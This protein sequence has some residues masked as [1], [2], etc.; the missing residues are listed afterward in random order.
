MEH[1]VIG[2]H[3]LE[4]R[5]LIQMYVMEEDVWRIITATVS[6]DT[7]VLNVNFIIAMV[8]VTITHRLAAAW[9]FVSHLSYVIA[10]R[11]TTDHIANYFI[12]LE[13]LIRTI[14][15]VDRTVNVSVLI[16]AHVVPDIMATNVT[17]FHV[18]VLVVV[19]VMCAVEM[20]H[21]LLVTSVTV[22]LVMK[23]NYV[24][25]IIAMVSVTVIHWYVMAM[26]RV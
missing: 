20:V 16:H 21:V 4:F 25:N 22:H 3:V 9:V 12:V 7:L 23:V 6:Q 17:I 26:V 2:H 15:H 19:I 18:M 24:M 8:Y 5:V 13:Y 14:H 11:G 10:R 1:I